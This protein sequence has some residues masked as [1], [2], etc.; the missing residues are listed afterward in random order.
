VSFSGGLRLAAARLN[1]I[2]AWS[3]LTGLVGLIIRGLEE[4][5][6]IVGRWIVGFIGIAWSVASVFVVPIIVMET[7]GADPVRFLKTSAAMLKKTWGESLIGYLGIRLGGMLAFM[8][9]SV[10]LAVIIFLSV[11]FEN[12]WFL[13]IAIVIWFV[14]LVVF[15][16][17][18]NV[19]GNVY[20]GALY[21]YAAEGAV[22]APF[23]QDQ[24][25]MAWK[26]K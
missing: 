7:E 1:A 2:L 3:L 20:Q 24:M 9:S 10:M 14:S 4:R 6:G 17:L 13:G 19:A 5:V 15:M 25:N 21:V 23:D 22:P 16:Y 8:G 26:V 11:A 12:L 18:L